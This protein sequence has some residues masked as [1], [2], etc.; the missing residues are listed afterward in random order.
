MPPRV[1]LLIHIS[2]T[3]LT[4]VCVLQ[5]SWWR[6]RSLLDSKKTHGDKHTLTFSGERTHAVVTGLRPFSEYSLI[7][8][9]FNGRGN[10][11]GS[12]PVIFETPEGGEYREDPVNFWAKNNTLAF[13]S[14][15]WGRIEVSIWK[16]S[17]CEWVYPALKC[18]VKWECN[19]SCDWTFFYPKLFLLEKRKKNVF[20]MLVIH[21]H[22][23]SLSPSVP[24]QVASFRATNIQKHKVTLTWSS[25]IDANG[26]LIS[27]VLQYQLST[28]TSLFHFV[29]NPHH[30]N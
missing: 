25:P 21:L 11:P 27:Y 18:S 29:H 5:V 14:Y 28:W 1:G 15:T 2:R 30:K 16:K 13:V 23:L 17:K 8:M 3:R 12:H 22:S 19:T 10:G 6:L 26:V 7:V 24:G 9:A 20:K 4:N